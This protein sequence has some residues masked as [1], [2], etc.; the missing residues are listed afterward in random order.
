MAAT[1]EE[2]V[3]A[4]LGELTY[5]LAVFKQMQGDLVERLARLEGLADQ[6]QGRNLTFTL[7]QKT[8]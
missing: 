7:P 1:L 3:K 4:Q 5:Q 8:G 2:I 6:M